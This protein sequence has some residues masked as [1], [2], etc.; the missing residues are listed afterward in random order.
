LCPSENLKSLHDS[1]LLYHFL[2]FLIFYPYV[3]MTF[4]SQMK[5]L[6]LFCHLPPSGNY[7]VLWI[8]TCCLESYEKPP[9]FC[10]SHVFGFFVCFCTTGAWTLG[11]HLE[12]LYQ[13]FFCVC[14]GFLEPFAWA[15][16]KPRSSW[17]LPASWVAMAPDC[18][19]HV[20]H[21]PCLPDFAEPRKWTLNYI[22]SVLTYYLFFFS[23][24]LH[25]LNSSV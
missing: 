23:S 2:V 11:L 20:C 3:I 25:T 18:F 7:N 8:E 21:S 9:I 6:L 15:G 17:S 5:R 24:V 10:F 14:N 19:S 13:P 1:F 4:T 16:F 22:I 12:P